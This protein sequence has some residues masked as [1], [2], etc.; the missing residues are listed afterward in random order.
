MGRSRWAKA[1]GSSA[2]DTGA[3]SIVTIERIGQA[4]ATRS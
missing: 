1:R 3:I 4:G 2:V